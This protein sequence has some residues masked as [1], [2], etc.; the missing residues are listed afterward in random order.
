MKNGETVSIRHPSRFF[1]W[2][3]LRRDHR[4]RIPEPVQ[5]EACMGWRAGN[6]PGVAETE[7]A[8][9][10][11][12]E[13]TLRK[14]AQ[15]GL[16]ALS[17]E[18]LRLSGATEV[19]VYSGRHRVASAGHRVCALSRSL[20]HTRALQVFHGTDGRTSLVVRTE[21]PIA[22]EPEAL[23]RLADFATLLVAARAKEREA[24]SRQAELL[25]ERKRLKETVAWMERQ[26]RR[27]SHDL[28]SPL[29][30]IQGYV[31][32][33]VKGLAGPLTPKLQRY[34]EHL[35]KASKDQSALIE[36]RLKPEKPPEDL[37]ALL[38]ATFERPTEARRVP[39]T[40]QFSTPTVWVK[41]ARPEL[42]ILVRTL[43]R[44]LKAAGACAA[45]LSVA[46]GSADTWKLHLSA[47][48]KHPLPER[49]VVQLEHL[50][51]RLGG[52]LTL[53]SHP[54][55]ELTLTLPAAY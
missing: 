49:T 7:R 17:R 25:R 28:R 36:Q 4:M 12:A 35:L 1:P 2:A 48:T 32:M 38:S 44:G 43:E 51:A 47:T 14:G 22:S 21:R 20:R 30:V 5:A 11:V 45:D 39:V 41:G 23:T 27:A 16:D 6:T 26:R 40:L 52:Q 29:L 3:V 31:G 9:A 50:A 54:T 42:E 15:A 8:L 13:H 46:Q 10:T 53:R 55:L 18:A 33:M 19:A 34:V 37:R 24:Q